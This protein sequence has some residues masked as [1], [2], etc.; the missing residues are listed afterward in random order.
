[1][2]ELET[3]VW[4]EF[5]QRI[6]AKLRPEY[7][8]LIN[9][10]SIVSDIIQTTDIPLYKIITMIVESVLYECTGNG[11]LRVSCNS[12]GYSNKITD[13]RVY[14]PLSV[15]RD[16]YPPYLVVLQ[17]NDFFV[18]LDILTYIKKVISRVEPMVENDL[19]KLSVAQDKISEYLN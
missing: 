14:L 3:R 16:N 19:L 6:S 17:W 1:M 2:N 13:I 8:D 11:I 10:S 18:D 5:Y 7:M 15:N 9:K 12:L 4:N